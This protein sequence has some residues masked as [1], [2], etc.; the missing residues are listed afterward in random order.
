M[1]S[2]RRPVGRSWLRT[3]R[4]LTL[5]VGI[6]FASALAAE[7]APP[8]VTVPGSELHVL[9][10]ETIGDSFTL[11]VALP[12]SYGSDPERRYPV[13]FSLDADMGFA[14]MAGTLRM[15]TIGQELP[16]V[17]LVAQGY[18]EPSVGRVMTSRS[19]DY[20]PIEAEPPAPIEGVDAPAWP[21]GG[22]PAFLE[23]IREEVLPF[24]DGRFRTNGERVFVG[25][26]YG[27]LFGLYTLFHA[28]DTFQRY[29][30]GSPSVWFGKEVSYQY[31]E[32][33]AAKH[34]DLA[35]KVFFGVGFDEELPGAPQSEPFRM[36][37]NTRKMHHRLA[38]RG[39]PSLEMEIV[40]FE[41]ES[42]MSVVPALM[43]RGLRWLLDPPAPPEAST[44]DG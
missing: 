44:S 24:V 39:Y 22:A 33:F 3:P 38:G 10:S 26:S 37:S 13:V 7:E 16:D 27:G 20:T 2:S 36:V 32:A 18:A 21:T 14:S 23:F 41:E 25:H 31:E 17:I 42:H 8:P 9:Q 11:Q 43:S 19:R 1:Q 4:A 15:G 40:L 12:A 5:V 30:I 29:L 35:A 6:T 34:D 28:P